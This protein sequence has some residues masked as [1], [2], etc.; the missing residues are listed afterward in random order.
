[1]IRS[2]SKL[3]RDKVT[4]VFSRKITSFGRKEVF[5]MKKIGVVAI[6][7]TDRA[8]AGTVQAVLSEFADIISGRMGIPDKVSGVCAISVVVEG[9]TE[10]ISALTGKLGRIDSVNVKSAITAVEID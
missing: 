4:F 5:Y 1:M 6:I 9:E 10:R 2:E 8:V 3:D 7:V